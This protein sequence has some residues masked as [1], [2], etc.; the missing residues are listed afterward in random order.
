[1]GTYLISNI[2]SNMAQL[3]SLVLNWPHLSISVNKRQTKESQG[4]WQRSFP[5]PDLSRKIYGPPSTSKDTLTSCFYPQNDANPY[6]NLIA[7]N[8]GSKRLDRKGHFV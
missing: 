6:T 4:S 8:I 1:M 5:L 2:I 7:R 3:L